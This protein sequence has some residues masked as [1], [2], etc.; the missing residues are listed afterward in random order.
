[1]GQVLN[2]FCEKCGY[3]TKRNVGT[4]RLGIKDDVAE[5]QLSEADFLEWKKRRESENYIFSA[6]RFALA[7][8]EYCNK[9]QSVFT[10]D[11]RWKDGQNFCIGSKCESCKQV[12][13]EISAGAQM[14]CPNCG[15]GNL[16]TK[17]IGIWD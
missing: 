2:I 8:C 13:K 17:T 15:Q 12:L 7:Y 6:W 3:E 16:E 1:M 4:G 11:V 9:I 5:R 14:V 10:A